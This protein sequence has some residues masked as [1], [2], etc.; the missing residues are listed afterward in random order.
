MSKDWY[1]EYKGKTILKIEDEIYGVSLKMYFTDGTYAIIKASM[2]EFDNDRAN[3]NI[4]L[5]GWYELK[6]SF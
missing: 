6:R 5:E 4:E 1:S 3:L 2:D